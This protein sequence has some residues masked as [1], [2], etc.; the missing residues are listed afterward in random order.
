MIKKQNIIIYLG[1][2]LFLGSI[3]FPLI[4]EAQV[5]VT[6]HISK[7]WNV[8]SS[9][10]EEPIK[11]SEIAKS[12]NLWT[13]EGKYWSLAYDPQTGWTQPNQIAKD[14]GVYVLSHE[15]C[16]VKLKGTP[17]T[18]S[19]KNLKASWNLFSTETS[20]NEIKGNCKVISDPALWEY[21]PETENWK[22]PS[23]TEKLDQS[24]GYWVAVKNDCILSSEAAGLELV[25]LRVE[26]QR[27]EYSGTLSIILTVHNPT[28]ATISQKV[29]RKIDEGFSEKTLTVLPGT[30][31]TVWGPTHASLFDVGVHTVS[32]NGLT[33]TFEVLPTGLPTTSCRAWCLDNW[34]RS[35]LS[36]VRIVGVGP[37][38]FETT[39]NML[40]L[41]KSGEIAPGY[42]EI[43]A[44]HPDYE[45]FYIS[46][47]LEAG[48]PRRLRTF[49]M[50]PLNPVG[51]LFGNLIDD[52]TGE[53]ILKHHNTNTHD[54]IKV[55]L[56][57]ETQTWTTEAYGQYY[58]ESIPMSIKLGYMTL[59][60]ECPT[61]WGI[62]EDGQP[63][64]YETK[65]IDHVK[66][67]Y[68]NI[69]DVTLKRKW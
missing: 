31:E 54:K 21:D 11:L 24:K 33:T 42:Y 37:T 50:M 44:T 61:Y 22:H 28:S 58:F 15:D 43:T 14:E 36:G 59:T 12:C 19:S 67:R 68:D 35:R 60:F 2:V 7:N 55:T 62:A 52:E 57:S 48:W 40:G 25:S 38:P 64:K 10:F 9:P 18:F 17:A 16:Q 6:L 30:H 63:F 32:V 66:I 46:V 45:T 5:E 20:W 51:S 53:N 65:I 3:F 69:L 8:I 47:T 26:P 29:T 1:L 27:V 56:K 23:L 41:W 4:S 34:S 49:S 13:Y 39:S